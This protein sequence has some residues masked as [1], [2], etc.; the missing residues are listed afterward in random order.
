MTVLPIKKAS[1]TNFLLVL[2]VAEVEI[3]KNKIWLTVNI[4]QE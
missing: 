2:L 1:K 3:R 4:K